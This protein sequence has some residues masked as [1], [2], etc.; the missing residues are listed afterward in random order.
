MRCQHS[1]AEASYDYGRNNLVTNLDT[2]Q[3]VVTVRL[4]VSANM[5]AHSPASFPLE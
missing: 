4:H 3:T 1:R 2:S 5:V